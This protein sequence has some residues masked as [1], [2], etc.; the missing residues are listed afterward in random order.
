VKAHRF[1]PLSLLLGLVVI[2]SGVA[3]INGHIGNLI[4]D[5]P[6]ALIPGVLLAFGIV[7]IAVATRR[8]LQ[9]VDRTGDDQG[10][11]GQ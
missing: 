4:N 10:N 8:S 5:R 11:G 9:D 1:D 2:I 3:A 6:H 7:A